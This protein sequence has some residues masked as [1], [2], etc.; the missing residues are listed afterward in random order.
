MS[1]QTGQEWQDRVAL[2]EVTD[3]GVRSD[4]AVAVR[5]T[6]SPDD[7]EPWVI[8]DPMQDTH[9]WGSTTRLV[10]EG[11]I[12]ADV[13]AMYSQIV[14]ESVPDRTEPRGALVEKALHR[15]EALGGDVVEILEIATMLY[16][17]GVTR[18]QAEI[19]ALTSGRGVLTVGALEELE[20]QGITTNFE[21]Y[22]A[23]GR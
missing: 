3:V 19:Y 16:A 1:K 13:R 20:K 11:F 10:A 6:T 23:E 17:W 8:K 21:T 4:G 18:E 14:E 22:R 15:I 2:L 12:P 5:T 9:E 7:L